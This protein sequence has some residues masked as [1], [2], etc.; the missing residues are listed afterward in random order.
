LTPL[1]IFSKI[2]HN[3]SVGLWSFPLSFLRFLKVLYRSRQLDT[4]RDSIQ[5]LRWQSDKPTTMGPAKGF[6]LFYRRQAIKGFVFT[7]FLGAIVLWTIK[8]YIEMM[9]HL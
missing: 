5:I 6:S 7:L 3:Q 8:N 4:R 2:P 9:V 1:F